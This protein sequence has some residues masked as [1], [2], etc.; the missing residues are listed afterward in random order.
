[1]KSPPLALYAHFPWCVQK[2]PYC[3]FNS[4]TLREEL[5]EQRYI[6]ALLRDLE[7]QLPDVEVRPLASIFMGGGTP[8]LF[9]PSAIGRLLESVRAQVGFTDGIEI[10]LEANPGTIERGKFAE[11]RAAGV[12]RVSLGAQSFDAKQLARLGR[13]HSADETRRAA[14]EL[15]ASGLDNFNLDLMYALPEQTPDDALADLTAALALAPAHLSQYHL[16]IEPGT[17]FAAAPPVQ[18]ADEVVDEMLERSLQ[19]LETSGFE[20]YEV[21][22]YARAGRRCVHNLNYWTFG[23]YLGIGAGAHG[24]VSDPARDLIVRTQ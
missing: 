19:V 8:S 1:M 5:P 16:T 13:I 15:H 22:G 17:V 6:D 10:T 24:K 2:C 3:D 12:T 4:H 7:A 9:S 18:P 21:S 11:Y 20:Q 23:D 14:E